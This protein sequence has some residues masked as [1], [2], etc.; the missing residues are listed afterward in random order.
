MGER[1]VIK[2][3]RKKCSKRVYRER[4]REKEYGIPKYAKRIEVMGK[5]ME[6]DEKEVGN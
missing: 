5:R 3:C 6:K 2:K 1:N 4:K